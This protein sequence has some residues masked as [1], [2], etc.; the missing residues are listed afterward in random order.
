ML[1]AELILSNTASA[2][3]ADMVIVNSG[4]SSRVSNLQTHITKDDALTHVLGQE[5]GYKT[6]EKR[7]DSR[8]P[9]R[10][11][12]KGALLGG[13]YFPCACALVLRTERGL[14]SMQ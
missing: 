14:A 10:T 12:E 9:R 4:S 5:L 7:E 8:Q 3:S 11:D 1:W 13:Y 2:D 6:L